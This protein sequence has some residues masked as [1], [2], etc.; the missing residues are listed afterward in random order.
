MGSSTMRGVNWRD[1]AAHAASAIA[2]SAAMRC[3]RMTQHPTRLYSSEECGN[4]HPRC[5]LLRERQLPDLV[6]VVV[7]ASALHQRGAGRDTP[8]VEEQ[9]APLVLDE[10]RVAGDLDHVERLVGLAVAV[11]LGHR[12]ASR[13]R[14]VG[15]VDVETA[16]VRADAVVTVVAVDVDALE[17]ELLAGAV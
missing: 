12:A 7:T 9:A 16:V 8:G 3:T 2:G 13:R 5:S 10:V 15:D 17:V 6:V 14:S 11:L 4:A 1:G